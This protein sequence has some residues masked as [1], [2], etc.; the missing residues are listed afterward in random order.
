MADLPEVAQWGA[1]EDGIYQL[2]LED[3]ITGGAGGND[4]EPH[5]ILA[6]RTRWLKEQ[7]IALN[8]ALGGKAPANHTHPYLPFKQNGTKPYKF[9]VQNIHQRH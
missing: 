4:N 8:N 2:E 7:M 6:N 5:R 3:F 9:K 1:E